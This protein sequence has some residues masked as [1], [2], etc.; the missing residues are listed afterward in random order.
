MRACQHGM[1]TRHGR[2][3][4][5]LQ[6][7]CRMRRRTRLRRCCMH[8]S[9][10]ADGCGS[11]GW[12]R[13]C[14]CATATVWCGSQQAERAADATTTTIHHHDDVHLFPAGRA[15]AAGPSP[16]VGHRITP[17]TR[18]PLAPRRLDAAADRGPAGVQPHHCSAVARS[19]NTTPTPPIRRE[20]R[21]RQMNPGTP[22][23]VSHD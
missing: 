7:N 6:W 2:R 20:L 21:G 11:A 19:L 16:V 3:Y 1:R 17:A 4:V 8:R 15:A 12:H 22:H 13:C 10:A 14:S 9:A 18:T 23:P 5:L